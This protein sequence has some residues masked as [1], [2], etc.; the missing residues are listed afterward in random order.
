MSACICFGRTK[1]LF[2]FYPEIVI[3]LVFLSFA[4]FFNHRFHDDEIFSCFLLLV[5]FSL[6]YYFWRTFHPRSVSIALSIMFLLEQLLQFVAFNSTETMT[7]W[8]FTF[9]LFY[10][11]RLSKY[12]IKLQKALIKHWTAV[13]VK[14]Q[15]NH[16]LKQRIKTKQSE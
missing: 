9:S 8:I 14:H 5:S 15:T 7:S 2:D 12:K 13:K 11:F 1:Q 4:C 3:E 16:W 10:Y 6:S